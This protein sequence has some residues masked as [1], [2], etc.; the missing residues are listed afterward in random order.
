MAETSWKIVKLDCLAQFETHTN[1]VQT[2]H[3][4]RKMID[5]DYQAET[6]GECR[7]SAPTG[8]FIAYEN[9]TEDTVISWLTSTLDT[10]DIDKV[11]QD[12]INTQKMPVVIVPSLPWP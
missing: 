1:V 8:E 4:Q 6:Y 10:A 11:L 3:W 7:L 9:L 5:G 2:I 12:N